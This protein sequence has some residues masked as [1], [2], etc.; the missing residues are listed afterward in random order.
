MKDMAVL[1]V[2]NTIE[3]GHDIV[4]AFSQINTF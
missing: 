1:F 4:E 2:N 3:K